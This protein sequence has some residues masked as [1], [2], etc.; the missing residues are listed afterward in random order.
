MQLGPARPKRFLLL[1]LLVMAIECLQVSRGRKNDA[2]CM[3]QVIRD[4]PNEEEEEK[5]YM[6]E[7]EGP[8]RVSEH[9][10]TPRVKDHSFHISI[11]LTSLS[12]A[13]RSAPPRCV[14]LPKGK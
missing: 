7:R 11:H 3:T 10:A 1:L 2:S 4:E 14:Y 5:V 6:G 12:R 13:L 8:A 9:L